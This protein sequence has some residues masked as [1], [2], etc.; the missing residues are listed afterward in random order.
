M[1]QHPGNPENELSA[2]FIRVSAKYRTEAKVMTMMATQPLHPG[3]RPL[4][5]RAKAGMNT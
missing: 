4:W 5:N 3:K 1:F 2:V